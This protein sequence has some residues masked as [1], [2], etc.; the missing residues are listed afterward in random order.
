MHITGCF[1]FIQSFCIEKKLH[2]VRNIFINFLVLVKPPVYI[3]TIK[4][5]IKDKDAFNIPKTFTEGFR[6]NYEN[7]CNFTVG[8]MKHQSL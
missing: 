7:Q 2:F 8:V 6:F 4:E 3:F 1:T 5:E